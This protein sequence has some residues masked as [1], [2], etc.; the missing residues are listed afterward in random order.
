MAEP[1][2]RVLHNPRA[3]SPATRARGHNR[4][5]FVFGGNICGS[6][7]VPMAG[8]PPAASEQEPSGAYRVGGDIHPPRK[9]KDVPPVYPAEALNAKVQGVVLLEA[10]VDATGTVS[11]AK[12][13]RSIPLLDQAALDAVKQWEYEPT[14]LNGQP[15]PVVLTVTVNFTLRNAPREAIGLTIATPDGQHPALDVVANGGIGTITIAARSVNGSAGDDTLK[16]GFAASVDPATSSTA[17]QVAVFQFPQGSNAPRLLGTVEVT[18]GGGLVYSP[19]T[20]SFGIEAV[21]WEG[22]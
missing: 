4:G 1:P 22:H 6:Q 21:R 3:G 15:V 10:T 14:L 9:V 11:D 2:G 20:P 19:T 7:A 5:E 17:I 8:R 13:L 18:V 16:F 12:V